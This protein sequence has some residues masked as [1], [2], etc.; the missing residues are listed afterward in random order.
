[1]QSR[2][3][4]L[5]EAV[6]ASAVLRADSFK[7]IVEIRPRISWAEAKAL[8]SILLIFLITSILEI[9]E[10]A[11]LSLKMFRIADDSDSSTTN[12]R[13]AELSKYQ[14]KSALPPAFPL[15]PLLNSIRSQP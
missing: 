5:V 10:V 7:G 15:T 1:M 4:K 6:I 3:F 9:T 8:I 12:F 11:H 13:I 14:F 2:L